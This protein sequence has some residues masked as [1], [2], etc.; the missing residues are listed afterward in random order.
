MKTPLADNWDQEVDLLV[1][2]TGAAGL[3]ATLTA[4]AQGSEVLVL[5]KTEFLGGTTAYSAGTCWVPNNR[6]QREDGILDDYDRTARYLDAVV[7][8][9][10]PR[11]GWLAYLDAAPKM[12]DAMHD[13]GVTFRRSP[14]VVDYHSELPETG[15][16][17]RALEPDP[18]DGRLLDKADFRRVRPP[19]PE[20][21][22]LG[23]TLM[24]R[25]ADV[26]ALLKLYNGSLAE[27]GK[28][29]ALAAR[30]GLRWALDRLT[31]PRGTRLVMGN[32]LV[33]RMFHESR[34]RGA[35]FLFGA[36]TTELLKEGDR[37]IGAV[38]LHNGTRLRI[39]SR[40]G[41]VLAAG[42]FAQSAE[43]R[44]K[45][46][47][48]PTP[49]YSRAG[50]GSTGDT[51]SLATAAGATLGMDN[52]ENALWFPSSIGR[53]RDG[54]RVVFPHIWDRARPGVI[55]VDSN[56]LRF[57]DESCSYHRFVRAMFASPDAA[58]VPAWLVVDSRTLAKYGLGMITM[59]HLPRAALRRYIKDG[60]LYEAET[61]TGLAAQIGV[62]PAGLESTVQR[63]NGFAATGVD[64]DF[65]KGELLFGQVAGDPDHG[66]NPNIGPLLKAPFYAMAVVP[67]PLATAYGVL[68]DG[69]GQALD[70]EGKPVAGLY[71]AG[72]DAASVMGSEYPGAGVQVGSGMTFG[73]QAGRHAAACAK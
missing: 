26:S 1:L 32:G 10:A 4:A 27:R 6:F 17:G 37:V 8:G 65:H 24:L 41:V 52:G 63:Y 31:R 33:A 2:G 15:K 22:L 68:T 9:K 73:W 56:G 70:T 43:M 42:G 62:D 12:L 5:E 38:V 14:A 46:L 35:E 72:N 11:E 20:F 36:Q 25:R 71:A 44:E 47:P 51:L 58:A 28:A 39:R 21:A 53:R 64:E 7:G 3:S 50:E 66:P 18:F 55:A 16:T 59:P 40:Q 19:V 57:V 49:L 13:L 67:T 69:N 61:L 54:S 30:L 23:G 34:K 48:S 60:Y 45:L 29:V